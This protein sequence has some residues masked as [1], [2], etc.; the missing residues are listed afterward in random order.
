M[1]NQTPPTKK[2]NIYSTTAH[3]AMKDGVCGIFFIESISMF[4]KYLN[5]HAKGKIQKGE[6]IFTY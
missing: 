3:Q 1:Y 6:K 5:S 4:I 2:T